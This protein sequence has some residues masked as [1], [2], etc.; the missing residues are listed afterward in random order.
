VATNHGL[1]LP[2]GD[3]LGWHQIHKATWSGTELVL[4]PAVVIDEVDGFTIVADGPASA[5]PLTEPGDLPQQVRERVTRSVALSV[6]H[7]VDGGGL[8]IAARRVPGHD[9]L[10]WTVRY[11][12]GTDGSSPEVRT[13]TTSLVAEAKAS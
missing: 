1:I 9:G 10:T 8:R 2:G 13:Q 5:Y 3:R 11:D 12:P 4:V 7:G 6:H